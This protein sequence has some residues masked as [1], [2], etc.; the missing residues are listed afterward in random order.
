MSDYRT[1]YHTQ[2]SLRGWRTTGRT[3]I[4]QWGSFEWAGG[5]ETVGVAEES[6]CVCLGSLAWTRQLVDNSVG[7]QGG[8]VFGSNNFVLV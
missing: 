1:L 5:T 3:K 4:V 7:G 6:I 2:E 8:G